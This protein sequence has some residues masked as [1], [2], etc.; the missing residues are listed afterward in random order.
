[1]VIDDI[2][3]VLLSPGANLERLLFRKGDVNMKAAKD[4]KT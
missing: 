2:W 3:D 1:M 4:L